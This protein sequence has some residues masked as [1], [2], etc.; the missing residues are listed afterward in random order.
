MCIDGMMTYIKNPGN[1]L[2]TISIYFGHMKNKSLLVRQLSQYL[3][4]LLGPLFNKEFF[5]D[6]ISRIIDKD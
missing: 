2:I 1:L 4:K 3:V 5:I 6:L